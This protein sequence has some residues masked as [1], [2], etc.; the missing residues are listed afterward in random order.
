MKR[1][2]EDSTNGSVWLREEIKR[3]DQRLKAIKTG[4]PLNKVVPQQEVNFFTPDLETYFSGQNR[5]L[6]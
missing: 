6:R 2:I 4:N 1:L 5:V 3:S